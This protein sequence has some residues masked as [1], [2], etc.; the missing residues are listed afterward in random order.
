MKVKFTLQLAISPLACLGVKPSLDLT[1]RFYSL[2]SVLLSASLG[3]LSKTQRTSAL[4]HKSPSFYIF[5]Y[6]HTSC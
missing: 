2:C 3:T 5:A 6:K 4:C 1:T